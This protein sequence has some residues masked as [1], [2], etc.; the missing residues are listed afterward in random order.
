MFD[1]IDVWVVYILSDL[2]RING[3]SFLPYHISKLVLYLLYWPNKTLFLGFFKTHSHILCLTPADFINAFLMQGLLL[4][5]HSEWY[6]EKIYSIHNVCHKIISDIIHAFKAI[7]IKPIKLSHCTNKF[8]LIWNL[9][10]FPSLVKIPEIQIWV[11]SKGR[12]MISDLVIAENIIS[13]K[14]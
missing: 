7:D 4:L 5:F 13:Y 12:K 6:R 11:H 8:S 3:L 10:D 9:E 14:T 2:F 1:L